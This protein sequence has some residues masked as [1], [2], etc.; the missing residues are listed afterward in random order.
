MATWLTLVALA[1]RLGRS[2]STVRSWRNR[3][4]DHV[5]S[6]QT[7]EGRTYSL[8]RMQEIEALYGQGLNAREVSAELE[9]RHG[10]A[11]ECTAEPATLDAVLV[12]LRAIRSA[13]E[14]LVEH[15]ERREDAET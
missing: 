4:A 11:D 13:V 14:R 3:H 2:E 6:Q 10:S 12:E 5:S 1:R 15:V 8:E 7:A 9:R